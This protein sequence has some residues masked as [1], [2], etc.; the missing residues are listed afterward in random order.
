MGRRQHTAERTV[1]PRLSPSTISATTDNRTAANLALKLTAEPNGSYSLPLK[2]ERRPLHSEAGEWTIF[3]RLLPP[4][5]SASNGGRNGRQ[6]SSEAHDI[7]GQS[8][9]DIVELAICWQTSEAGFSSVISSDDV[10]KLSMENGTESRLSQAWKWSLTTLCQHHGRMDTS[11]DIRRLENGQFI[12][13]FFADDGHF[14]ILNSNGN[15]LVL[16]SAHVTPLP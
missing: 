2:L 4:T 1:L 16:R 6:A 13:L 14:A 10:G 15:R 9:V 3:P 11:A 8:S 5:I 7:A 12:L